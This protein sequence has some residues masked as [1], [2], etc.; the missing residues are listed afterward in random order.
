MLVYWSVF[1]KIPQIIGCQSQPD[2]K[3][4]G[5]GNRLVQLIL[6]TLSAVLEGSFDEGWVSR[7][8]EAFGRLGWIFIL[9]K[10]WETRDVC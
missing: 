2:C 5:D 4:S 10:S 3:E 1:Q 7:W 9:K 8:R 6:E